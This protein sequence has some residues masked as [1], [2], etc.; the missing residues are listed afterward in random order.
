MADPSPATA[1]VIEAELRFLDPAVQGS[2]A[3]LAALLHPEFLSFGSSGR[4]W[5]R[6]TLV[7]E[8]RARGPA[9]PPPTVSRLDA[10]ELADG[11]VHVTFDV[12]AGGRRAHR[13][14]VWRH[15][16]GEWLLYFHQ[17]TAFTPGEVPPQG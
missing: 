12:E 9:G 14:S 6:E 13:S 11:V 10:V 15:T 2:P 4:C 16:G 3:R 8:L 17:G 1:A 7:A 5:N